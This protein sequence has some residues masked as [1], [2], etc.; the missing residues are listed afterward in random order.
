MQRPDDNS[1]KLCLQSFS[2]CSPFLIGYGQI[3]LEVQ[4]RPIRPS[5]SYLCSFFPELSSFFLERLS[6]SSL[7]AKPKEQLGKYGKTVGI[8]LGNSYSS[9]AIWQNDKVEVIPNE[10]VLFFLF[11]LSLF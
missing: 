8:S 2:H 5:F 4:P 9:V 7:V 10:M 6:F 11:F 1:G 3:P